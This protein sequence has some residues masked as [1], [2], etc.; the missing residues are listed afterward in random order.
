ML[1]AALLHFWGL[2]VRA[3]LLFFNEPLKRASIQASIRVNAQGV[4]VETRR[5]ITGVTPEGKSVITSDDRP[6]GISVQ[7][8]PGLE[9]FLLWGTEG[10][11]S[12]LGP[13]D[14]AVVKPYFPALGGTRFLV[15]RWAPGPSGAR[16]SR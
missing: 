8:L 13:R 11:H 4:S 2:R 9:F 12:V 5:V 15:V 3:S 14:D 7:A 10:G 6:D 16:A 1:C